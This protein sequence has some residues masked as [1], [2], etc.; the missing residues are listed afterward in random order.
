MNSVDDSVHSYLQ[1]SKASR[2]RDDTE[3]VKEKW[4][5]FIIKESFMDKEKHARLSEQVA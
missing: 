2:C 4:L 3:K 5:Y 1:T